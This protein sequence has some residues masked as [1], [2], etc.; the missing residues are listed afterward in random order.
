MGLPPPQDTQDAGVLSDGF[1]ATLI[2]FHPYPHRNSQGL[3]KVTLAGALFPPEPRYGISLKHLAFWVLPISLLDSS[4][5]S[6]LGWQLSYSFS[7]G[8]EAMGV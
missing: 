7:L 6:G 3:G 1:I 8:P 4:E 5:L 2:R